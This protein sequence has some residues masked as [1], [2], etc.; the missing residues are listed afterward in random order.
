MKNSCDSFFKDFTDRFAAIL[1]EKVP[2]LADDAAWELARESADS[3]RKEWAGEKIYIPKREAADMAAR[4]L[5]IWNRFDGTNS[6]DL[7]RQYD[8][9][10]SR[11]YQIVRAVDLEMKNREKNLDDESL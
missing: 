6:D 3:L 2:T 8:L 10:I 1:R 9:T 4:N 7:C 11:L 5:E